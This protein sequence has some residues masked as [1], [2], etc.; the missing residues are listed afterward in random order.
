[1]RR[2][3]VLAATAL[4]ALLALAGCSSPG[5][6]EMKQVDDAGIGD[7]ATLD[8]P[9]PP[10]DAPDRAH[11][12]AETVREAIATGSA[13]IDGTG[14]PVRRLGPY[15]T[16][17]GVYN[18]SYEVVGSHEETRADV[19]VDYDPEDASGDAIAYG[20]LPAV[21]RERVAPLFPPERDGGE[22]YDV[23]VGTRYNDSEAAESVLVGPQ[24][25]QVVTYE[26]E[27][28]R[29]DVETEPVTVNTYRYT[30]EEVAP[31]VA[32]Y[33]SQLREEYEFTLDGLSE[34]ERSVVE[35]AIDGGYT[36]DENGD[37]AFE[38]VIDE[39]QR[40]DAVEEDEHEGTWIVRYEGETY[41]VDIDYGQYGE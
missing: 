29:V 7:E 24:E 8:V 16:D 30:A 1:M 31:G 39:F 33:G 17:D 25:Y 23:G 32:A 36:A 10:P 19:R 3:T 26:G 20:D 40:H 34:E 5:S 41:W 6:M 14:P 28:Y 15:G 13:T 12:D 22:G 38:S 27:R 9:T 37:S 18:L 4:L 2:R 21:D 11:D 35:S